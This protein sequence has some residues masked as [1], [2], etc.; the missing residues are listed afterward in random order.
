MR[1]KGAKNKIPAQGRKTLFVTASISAYPE[2][3]E[4]LKTLAKERGVTLSKLV[5][6]ALNEGRL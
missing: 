3:M 5:I 4:R 6:N 2:D 1:T